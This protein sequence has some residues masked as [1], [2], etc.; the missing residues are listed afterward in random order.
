MLLPGD[1]KLAVGHGAGG[2]DDRVIEGAQVLE[3]HIDAVLHI[4]HET[5]LWLSQHAVQRLDDLLDARMVRRDAITDQAE[6]GRQPLDDVDR[7]VCVRFGEDVG[8]VDA[9]WATTDDRNAKAHV[10]SL[11]T[12]ARRRNE[13]VLGLSQGSLVTMLGPHVPDLRALELLV[14]VARTGSLGAAAADLGISQ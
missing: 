4:A 3:L 6:G 1:A 2:D 8:G 14:V 10:S 5:H 7:D 9:G 11:L 12:P 13:T